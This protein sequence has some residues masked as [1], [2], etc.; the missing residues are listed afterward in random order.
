LEEFAIGYIGKEVEVSLVSLAGGSLAGSMIQPLVD[1][2]F[3]Q[4]SLGIW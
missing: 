3:A 2:V 1:A 4:V